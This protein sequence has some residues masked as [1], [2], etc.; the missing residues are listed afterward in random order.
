MNVLLVESDPDLRALLEAMLGD[1]YSVRA[2]G[3]GSRALSELQDSPPDVL[4][5]DLALCGVS[6]EDLARAA[7]N[8]PR[9]PR[10]ILMSV[11]H[12]RLALSG[13][14]AQARLQKPFA[15]RDLVAAFDADY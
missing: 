6:G 10:V 4:L 11:D 8:L 7:A 1:R 9:P 5:T 13:G 14:L 3:C 2:F 12:K 15:V